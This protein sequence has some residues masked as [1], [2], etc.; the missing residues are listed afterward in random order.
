MS[1]EIQNI[2]NMTYPNA[3]V[4]KFLKSGCPFSPDGVGYPEKY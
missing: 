1:T 3:Q 2:L 4:H